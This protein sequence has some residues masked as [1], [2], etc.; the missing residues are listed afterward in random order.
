MIRVGDSIGDRMFEKTL[1]RITHRTIACHHPKK[2]V[3]SRLDSCQKGCSGEGTGW[4]PSTSSFA[5]DPVLPSGATF[6]IRLLALPTLVR[7]FLTRLAVEEMVP[8][9]APSD[10]FAQNQ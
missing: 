2:R 9:G 10:L 8:M 7:Y 1:I 6:S 3:I 5:M 4:K